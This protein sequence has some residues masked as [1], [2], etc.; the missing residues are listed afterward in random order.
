[1]TLSDEQRR[2]LVAIRMAKADSV[3]AD[4]AML[5]DHGSNLSAVNRCYYAMFHA[6]SALAIHDNCDF[7]KHRAVIAW[8][9]SE[10]VKTGRV[11]PELGAALQTVFQNRCD[12]DYADVTTFTSEQVTAMLDHA[13]RFV[14]EVKSI[15]RAT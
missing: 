4:A 3:L 15:L 14:A 6:A 5:A 2:Q 11:S 9:H 1:M 8:F 7:H 13:R 10:Y 12:A